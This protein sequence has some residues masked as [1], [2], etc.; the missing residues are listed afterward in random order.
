MRPARR[1]R[2]NSSSSEDE[3]DAPEDVAAQIA[4]PKRQQPVVRSLEELP[5]YVYDSTAPTLKSERLDHFVRLLVMEGSDELLESIKAKLTFVQEKRER[6]SDTVYADYKLVP[7]TAN[8]WDAISNNLVMQLLQ[9]LGLTAPSLELSSQYWSVPGALTPDDIEEAL[10]AVEVSYLKHRSERRAQEIEQAA[11]VARAKQ[12]KDS[13]QMRRQQPAEFATR[14]H[15]AF[16]ADTSVTTSDRFG[17]FTSELVKSEQWYALRWLK[18]QLS[19]TVRKSRKRRGHFKVKAYTEQDWTVL[20]SSSVMEILASLESL[21][22]SSDCNFWRVPLDTKRAKDALSKVLKLEMELFVAH[23]FA[24]M[25][26]RE[27]DDLIERY[28]LEQQRKKLS[29]KARDAMPTAEDLDFIVG[30]RFGASVCGC[31]VHVFLPVQDSDD[32]ASEYSSSSEG[33]EEDSGSAS[34]SEESASSSSD[35][36]PAKRMKVVRGLHS[37]VWCCYF[38]LH[39]VAR[40]SSAES[41][42]M[43]PPSRKRDRAPLQ[44]KSGKCMK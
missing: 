16:V 31:S 15:V 44:D 35:H 9:T 23:K 12:K 7:V 38:R 40:S 32:G 43:P 42:E 24:S 13:R 33:D 34:N 28:E 19:A 3:E 10:D 29:K 6:K 14:E 30:V 41:E 20:N 36:R 26:E 4:P 8:D 27:R 21:P 5:D 1:R 37:Y 17:Y 39:K 22:P 11:A 18:S 25:N 2:R